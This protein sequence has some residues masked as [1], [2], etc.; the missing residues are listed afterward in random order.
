MEHPTLK[1]RESTNPAETETPKTHELGIIRSADGKII[2]DLRHLLPEL[3]P[4]AHPE[5]LRLDPAILEICRLARIRVFEVFGFLKMGDTAFSITG[6]NTKGTAQGIGFPSVPE[7]RVTSK[8]IYPQLDYDESRGISFTDERLDINLFR[9][10]ERINLH[11]PEELAAFLDANIKKYLQ[12]ISE[13]K[14]GVNYLQL[15][16]DVIASVSYPVGMILI[17]IIKIPT[18][19][20]AELKHWIKNTLGSSLYLAIL[21]CLYTIN[22][23][24]AAALAVGALPKT[25]MLGREQETK[26]DR[27]LVELFRKDTGDEIEF[28]PPSATAIG[29]FE[30]E[31]LDRIAKIF[32]SK[33]LVYAEKPDPEAK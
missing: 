5:L 1:E 25:L 33:A 21:G 15:I 30:L 16:T 2:V 17:A 18:S 23:I 12:A 20:K 28:D 3:P 10:N 4:W 22:P 32:K 29:D 8:Q 13:K 7:N 11:K 14:L 9:L 26:N 24:L 6:A 27:R 19:K 31:R